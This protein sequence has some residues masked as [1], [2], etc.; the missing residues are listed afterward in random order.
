MQ[1]GLKLS[2]RYVLQALLGCGGMGEVWRGVD[3]HLGRPVAIKVLREH[4]ADPEPTGRFRREARIAARLQHP[5]ITVVHDVGSDDGQLFIVMEL[6]HGRDL[7]AMLAQAPAGLPIDTAVSLTIQAA[8]ALQAAHAGHVI[9]RDLKPANLFVLSSGQLK[10]CDFGIA[11]AVD[12][13]THL[14]ATGQAIGTPAYMSP[15]QCQGQQVDERSDLYS[16]GCVLYALLTG[17]PPFTEG[18]PLTIMLQHINAAPAAP[19]T[20]RPDT[21]SEL[22]RLV[23]ELLAKDPARRPADAG[24]VMAALRP[25]CYTPTVQV[26]PTAKV[27]SQPNLDPRE[28]AGDVSGFHLMGSDGT[29]SATPARLPSALPSQ[30]AAITQVPRTEA[31]RRQVLLTRPDYW[32]FLHFA[33]QLLHERNSVEVKYRD[34]ELRYAPMSGEVAV[35]GASASYIGQLND[36]NTILE[37]INR[38]MNDSMNLAQKMEDLFNDEAARERAFGAPGE[39]GD[40]E[41]LTHLAKRLNNVYEQFLDWAAGLRGASVPPEFRNLLELAARFADS[42]VK[43]YRRFVDEY[44]VQANVLLEDYAAG[45]P[46]RIEAH[47][48]LSISEEVIN[49]Y[50]AELTRLNSR[51]H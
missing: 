40:A 30:P 50:K 29:M 21:P 44:V 37:Y 10:I 32:E 18:Q 43:E 38:Q 45:R 51:L 4:L 13:A 34:Y 7:A 19:R 1:A 9:H 25:L 14:T 28:P 15:E 8:E 33:G 49:D 24:H 47:L 48:V 26:K 41:R 35:S 31:E 3:E 6:L 11:S 46:L 39:N 5:G 27:S 16:L 36:M 17:Q 20:I 42:P 12:S 22:D 2:G 23:L